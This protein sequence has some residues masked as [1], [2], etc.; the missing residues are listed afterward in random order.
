M[1]GEFWANGEGDLVQKYAFALKAGKTRKVPQRRLPME[2]DTAEI[3][4]MFGWMIGWT[5][6]WTDQ[7]SSNF[8]YGEGILENTPFQP[9]NDFHKNTY[10]AINL[11]WYPVER[12]F[13]DIEYLYGTRVD[14]D[15]NTGNANRL[16][17]SF[18][19][20]LP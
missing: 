8:T 13:A 3:L 6:D 14:N 18:G 19:F 9:A 15:R 12:M 17:M 1:T 2:P 10:F 5:R 16:Q 7:L 4:A 11:I 20:Y